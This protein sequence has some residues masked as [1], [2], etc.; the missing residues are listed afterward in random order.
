MSTGIFFRSRLK[1][2]ADR[3][4]Y[5]RWVHEVDLPVVREI[6]TVLSYEVVRI[7]GPW[8]DGD[9]PYDYVECIEVS[10]PDLYRRQLEEIPDRQG[11]SEAWQSFIGDV[12]A[13]R[14]AALD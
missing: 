5:E 6:P 3:D 7:D 14:G 9:V 2:G 8:R 10:D 1:A 4:A 13:V 11:F 12:V